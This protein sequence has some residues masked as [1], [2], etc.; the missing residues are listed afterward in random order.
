M[1]H[2]RNLRDRKDYP[3]FVVGQHD[4]NQK[5]P[6][7]EM[8]KKALSVEFPGPIHFNENNFSPLLLTILDWLEDRV[9]FH[10]CGDD[11]VA[12]GGAAFP[13]RMEDGVVPLRRPAGE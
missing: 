10:C 3:C 13:D 11:L 5:G 9:V 7:V 4:R 1:R 6:I 2:P 12:S 8:R